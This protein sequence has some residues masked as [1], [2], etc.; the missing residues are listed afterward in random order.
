MAYHGSSGAVMARKVEPSACSRGLDEHPGR[1]RKEPSVDHQGRSNQREESVREREIG[2]LLD[3]SVALSD[4][5]CPDIKGRLP[6]MDF[7]RPWHPGVS[8]QKFIR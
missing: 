6:L 3:S 4:E 8:E 2:K 1:D 7:L 5:T